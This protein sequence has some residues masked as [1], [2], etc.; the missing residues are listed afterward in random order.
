MIDV[1]V[2][3][4][5]HEGLDANPETQEYKIYL[6]VAAIN[7]APTLNVVG[8]EETQIFDKE[9]PLGDEVGD[10]FLVSSQEDTVTVITEI[11][12]WD[13]DYETSGVSCGQLDEFDVTTESLGEGCGSGAP[14]VQLG[15]ELSVSCTYGLLALSGR[16]GGLFYEEGDVD[17][18]K[19]SLT[20]FGTL[21]DV[22]DALSRGIVYTP[23]E[24]WS[25]VD[26]IKVSLVLI[27]IVC[28]VEQRLTSAWRSKAL[29]SLVTTSM[30][31]RRRLT[32]R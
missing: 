1:T 20:V 16:Q 29:L 14:P 3:D 13:V 15:M 9:S 10:A 32:P 22:N 23:L 25:G 4:Y 28:L 11:S 17:A 12:V 26:V 5:S 2:T 21:T 19:D 27:L 31:P 8:L 6:A 18:R 7:D 30:E 24:K